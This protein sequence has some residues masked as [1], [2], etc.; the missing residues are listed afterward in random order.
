MVLNPGKK[1]LW[2]NFIKYSLLL[3]NIY[4]KFNYHLAK[5]A[6]ESRATLWLLLIF[7]RT[8][9][10]WYYDDFSVTENKYFWVLLTGVQ[11]S[12]ESPLCEEIQGKFT[13][14]LVILWGNVLYGCSLF[15]ACQKAWLMCKCCNPFG[16]YYKIIRMNMIQTWNIWPSNISSLTG[17]YMSFHNQSELSVTEVWMKVVKQPISLTKIHVPPV[18]IVLV[19]TNY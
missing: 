3:I 11:A 4:F 13:S 17:H 5:L 8:K 1:V 6:Y 19:Q 14:S 7:K 10:M 9:M 2:K 15:N 16:L 12:R 18:D